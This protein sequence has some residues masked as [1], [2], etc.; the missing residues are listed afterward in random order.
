MKAKCLGC[1]KRDGY[2]TWQY[3]STKHRLHIIA[4]WCK[5]CIEVYPRMPRI[6][7]Q[8][9]LKLKYHCNRCLGK[10]SK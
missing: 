4:S 5:H 2:Q 7:A 10:I 3:F 8:H 6:K 1:G 9:K